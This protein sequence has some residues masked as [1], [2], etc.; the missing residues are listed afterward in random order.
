MGFEPSGHLC[1]WQLGL[2]FF[3]SGLIFRIFYTSHR[4]SL[5]MASCRPFLYTLQS[6]P[7]GQGLRSPVTRKYL[8]YGVAATSP[9]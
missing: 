9:E 3:S 8:Q 2:S 7:G 6:F 5:G 1:S 4:S